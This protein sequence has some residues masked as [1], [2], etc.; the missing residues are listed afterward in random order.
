MSDLRKTEEAGVRDIRSDAE[1][2]T[3]TILEFCPS[4]CKVRGRQQSEQQNETIEPEEVARG[5]A[6]YIVTERS[7]TTNPW[8]AV[9]G[10]DD[11]AKISRALRDIDGLIKNL[12]DDAKSALETILPPMQAQNDARDPVVA[13]QDALGMIQRVETFSSLMN[14]AAGNIDRLLSKE[15]NKQSKRSDFDHASMAVYRICLKI[16]NEE[17]L[18]RNEKLSNPPS[19]NTPTKLR[20]FVAGHD[21][22][23]QGR[24]FGE[25]FNTLGLN[26]N[27]QSAAKNLAKA[28][29]LEKTFYNYVVAGSAKS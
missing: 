2:V 25:V 29:G 12:S 18:A 10:I 8:G 1:E 17:L 20:K 6:D 5:L 15:E 7:R 27:L 23:E 13:L 11:L 4:L 14:R 28:G 3:E 24:F 26:P 19:A 9:P 16:W 21:E 22:D